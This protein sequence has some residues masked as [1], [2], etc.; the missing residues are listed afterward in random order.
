MAGSLQPICQK[1]SQLDALWRRFADAAALWPTEGGK[2]A[3]FEW[4]LIIN[5]LGRG[6]LRRLVKKVLGRHDMPT[7]GTKNE[8]KNDVE[9]GES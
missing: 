4:Q 3:Y 1:N 5:G 8:G 2:W 7:N 6:V 9:E